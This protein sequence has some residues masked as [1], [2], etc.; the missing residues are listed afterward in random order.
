MRR[1]KDIE[2]PGPRGARARLG[3]RPG[4]GGAVLLAAAYFFA[5][6]CGMY[7]LRPLREEMGIRGGVARL[8]RAFLATFVVML[9][10]VP[11]HGWLF[12]R[13]PRGHAVP[14]V[15]LFFASHLAV[16][17]A[18]FTGG[19][20][21]PAAAQAFFVWISV[22]NLFVVSV[23]W[24][25]M[26]DLFTSEQ[27]KRL[28]GVVSA[29]GSAG[30]LAGPALA[31]GLVRQVGVSGVIVLAAALLVAAAACAHALAR[32]ARAGADAV[33]REGDGVGGSPFAGFTA[34][35]R[36]PY[37]AALALQAILI[38]GTSTLLYFEQARVVAATL[39]DT[40]ERVRLF[41]LVDGAVNAASLAAQ[42]LAVG[43][44]LSRA[45]L[46]AGLFLHPALSVGGL[47]AVAAWPTL[48]V[49][50]VVQS[51]RRAVHYAVEQPAREVLFTVVP[52][53]E[54]YKAKL[55]VDTV[56]YRGGDAASG[57]AAG[58][59]AAFGVGAS[60]AAL[61]ALPVAF[62]WLAVVAYLARKH[63]AL[64]RS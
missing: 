50:A 53:E 43:P 47:C 3:V 8:D 2:E 46:A 26:A 24:S 10:A 15:Y 45:G 14:L 6:L 54:R 33:R 55:F 62:V 61:A 5:L 59:L 20:S 11:L 32:R 18:L 40:V 49:I 28:F 64:E 21:H 35:A 63:A 30:A 29:G 13:V 36:S 58:R 34:V 48:A 44:L 23:F 1:P 16:F 27:G 37:V 41:A 9:A 17:S 42:A 52:R 19:R 38:S 22:Y 31:A 39:H 56:A 25:L 51:L 12:A 7:L 4:E 60:G 57:V